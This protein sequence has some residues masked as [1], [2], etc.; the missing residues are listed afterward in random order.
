MSPETIAYAKQRQTALSG[1]QFSPAEVQDMI[2]M[3][4]QSEKAFYS[5][6][7]PE[8]QGKA[9]VDSLI[10]NNLRHSLDGAIESSTGWEYQPLKRKYGA[11]RM[12]ETD[13]TK[14]AIVDARKNIRG[15]VDF[16]DIFSGSQVVQGLTSGNMS[17]MLSGG[18]SRGIASAI[19]WIN[20]PNR[21]V[22]SMFQ[23]AEKY[24]TIK[25]G[26]EPQLTPGLV[27]GSSAGQTGYQGE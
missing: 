5:N 7:T 15:L 4:N 8:M 19:K 3:L 6:P 18:V 17:M 26:R 2:K 23:K 20:D 12:L 13:V 22:K 11:L 25:P 14:R 21:I 16:S 10:A 24:S 27:Y 9:Y 1:K